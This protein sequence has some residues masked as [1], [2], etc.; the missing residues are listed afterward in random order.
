MGEQK[1]GHAI[2]VGTGF[3]GA[4]TAHRLV[5]AGFEVC[6]LERGRRYA[7]NDFPSLPE[8]QEVFPDPARWAWS[9]T[10]VGTTEV[11]RCE[12]EKQAH[13]SHW[14][15]AQGL[16][17][18]RDLGG[19]VAAHAAGYGGGSLIYANVH[20]RA[21]EEVFKGWPGGITRKALDEYYDRVAAKLRI[22]PI[23]ESRAESR[24]GAGA[25]ASI[26]KTAAFVTAADTLKRKSFYPPLAIDFGKCRNCGEC[27]TGCRFGAK[28]TLDL[29]YLKDV[30]ACASVHTLAEALWVDRTEAGG[31][32]VTYY[33]HA[34]SKTRSAEGD[35]VFLCT[36][37]ISTTEILLRS[38][39]RAGSTLP[40]ISKKLGHH[41]YA[42]ADSLALA[43]DTDEPLE[44]SNGPVITAA[45][46]YRS[47]DGRWFLIED[48][49]YPAAMEKAA[50]AFRA[51]ALLGRNAYPSR[52][53]RPFGDPFRDR[54]AAKR[55]APFRAP[56]DGIYW[57]IKNGDLDAMVPAP[58]REALGQLLDGAHGLGLLEMQRI[59]P[60][61]TA[62]LRRDTVA[63]IL[64][65]LRCVVGKNGWRYDAAQRLLLG[66]A[67]CIQAGFGAKDDRLVQIAQD[68]VTK[69]YAPSVDNIAKIGSWLLDWDEPVDRLSHRAVLL[70]MGR[71]DSAG[72]ITRD[73]KTDELSIRLTLAPQAQTYSLQERLMRDIAG[74]WGAEL[75][76]NPIWAAAR[77]P[78]TVHHQGGCP[79]GPTAADGVVD[80]WGEVHGYKELFVFDGA[81]LPTAVGVNPSSTIAALAERNVEQF[82]KDHGVRQV[83]TQAEKDA[84][85]EWRAHADR[86]G[87]QIAPPDVQPSCDDSL[88]SD[89]IGI[90]FTEIM[91]G[92]HAP[93]EAP[94]PRGPSLMRFLEPPEPSEP[95][96]TRPPA[97]TRYA[98]V[99]QAARVN[100]PPLDTDFYEHAYQRGR[101]RNTLELTMHATIAD[102]AAFDADD[103]HRLAIRGTASFHWPDKNIAYDQADLEGEARLFVNGT[104]DHYRGEDRFMVY[105]LSFGPPRPLA[106]WNV[107]GFKRLHAGEGTRAWA[108]VTNLFVVV[109]RADESLRTYGVVR[110]PL[111][112]FLFEV[113]GKMRVRGA[114]AKTDPARVA[115]AT[116]LFGDVFFG[117]MADLYLPTVKR[118]LSHF[119][120]HPLSRRT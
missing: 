83:L 73:A 10:S 91:G 77:R 55:E 66:A 87:W 18:I 88:R 32:T 94:P 112:T 104:F 109:E 42:N 98:A 68:I 49:G 22:N 111:E 43:F 118:S 116:A 41:F 86:K 62:K 3:G 6:V 80:P 24:P 5:N 34:T 105:N 56:P 72:T 35:Y 8:K 17:D 76:V 102:V 36:G 31:Y 61:V 95:R 110:L 4:V 99:E 103:E 113:L 59:V 90:E 115:W 89:A 39:D 106:R 96:S 101:P 69:R 50:S 64:T 13:P 7:G 23:T 14:S 93:S 79:M 29:N 63:Q 30:D 12:A 74:E 119:F 47:D 70:G 11:G 120:T 21:P 85:A 44:P 27:D 92:F 16:W 15:T 117:H 33:D 60:D 52:A 84:I 46:P 67:A 75:R 108:D 45:I 81:I 114:D 26:P 100:D 82:L 37:S 40:G 65:W 58:L 51:R 1:K 48:G 71:D 9:P 28:N 20:L 38:R 57:M 78:I 107:T 53:G 97:P 2:V 25:G 19:V 54:V